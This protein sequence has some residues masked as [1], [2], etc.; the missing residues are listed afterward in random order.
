MTIPAFDESNHK[1]IADGTF[2]TKEQSAPELSI[3]EPVATPADDAYRAAQQD[4]WSAE[5][6]ALDAN[7]AAMREFV[8][9]KA[10]DVAT[11]EFSY[12]SDFDGEDSIDF[13]RALDAAGEPMDLDDDVHDE[14]NDYLDSLGNDFTSTDD[15]HNQ[16]FDRVEVDGA[17]RYRLTIA[18]DASTSLF[19]ARSRIR[20]A[21]QAITRLQKVRH[22]AAVSGIA[23]LV[24][25]QPGIAEATTARVIKSWGGLE[26]S[27]LTGPLE[28][29]PEYVIWEIDTSDGLANAGEKFAAQ[30]NDLLTEIDPAELDADPSGEADFE[31]KFA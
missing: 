13:A 17:D 16:D 8:A 23:A 9:A 18:A 22:D 4:A 19:R 6:R 31:I 5:S 1:R 28:D 11:V 15:I 24:R 10:P 29:S 25:E 30:V 20:E 26:V 3:A 2:T 7:V 14:L 27:A 12:H 21:N